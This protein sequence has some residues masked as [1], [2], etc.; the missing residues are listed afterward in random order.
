VTGEC[1][2]RDTLNV[3]AKRG[4]AGV[5]RRE[6]GDDNIM[7]KTSESKA[8]YADNANVTAYLWCRITPNVVSSLIPVVAIG[9]RYQAHLFYHR[10]HRARAWNAAD[11]ADPWVN[12]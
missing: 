10:N 8:K 3:S 5:L 1:N 4:R 6:P 7:S 2:C 11:V 12:L 9:P